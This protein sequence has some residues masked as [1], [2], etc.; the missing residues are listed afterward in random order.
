MKKDWE[1]IKVSR[2]AS[3]KKYFES[4]LLQN[5]SDG[6]DFL[7][8]EA[9]D[10]LGE[11]DSSEIKQQIDE[12][13]LEEFSEDI[14][15]QIDDVVVDLS[16][17]KE[18]II[19]SGEIP[20]FIRESS[21]NAKVALNRDEDY[22]RKAKRKFNRLDSKKNFVDAQ[23]TNLRII[24]L[25]DKAIYV[26]KLN[27]EAYC[28]KAKALVNLKEYDKAIEEYIN[29]LAFTPDD[30]DIRLAIANLNRLNCE[31]N[32]AIDVYDSVLK[33]DENCFEALRGKALTYYDW[34]KYGQA[35]KFFNEANS[36]YSL[37]D[38]DKEIWDKCKN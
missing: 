22:V 2:R 35:S 11:L 17:A 33:I 5:I 20:E 32:D 6:I 13:D 27:S 3:G 10:I 1:D 31:F 36:I 26:N 14:L 4:S 19:S 16:K 23:K 25:C 29:C 34:K 12:I 28:L 15:N 18:D 24:E 30:L 9:D 7:R 38:E 8:Q 21:R 37:D